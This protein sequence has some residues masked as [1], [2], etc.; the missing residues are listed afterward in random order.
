MKLNK[1]FS[2]L[3]G[4]ALVLGAA[5]CNE[6]AKYDPTPAYNGDEVYFSDSEES[7]V[8]IPSGAT[9]VT[10]NLYRVKAGAELTVGLEGTITSDTETPATSVFSVPT[11]VTFPAE[12]TVVE[13]PIGVTFSAVEP[14]AEYY[15]HLAIAG[16]EHTPYGLSEADFVLTYAPWSEFELYSDK[17]A[18]GT[19]GNPFL[20]E[21]IDGQVYYAKSLVN[22]NQEKYIIIGPRYS[23][24][25]FNYELTVDKSKTVERE[26]TTCYRV[27]MPWTATHYELNGSQFVFM[28]AFSYILFLNGISDPNRVNDE[29][30]YE[31]LEK[32][33]LELSYYNP[34]TGIFSLYLLPTLEG[35]EENGWYSTSF[36]YIQMPGFAKYE[37]EFTY[38]SNR[39]DKVTDQ[40]S[41][42]IQAFRTSDVASFSYKLFT[43]KLSEAEGAEEL[44]KLEADAEAT[45]YYDQTTVFD[46]YLA[47]PG[48]YTI[49]AVGYDAAGDK[50]CDTVWTFTYEPLRAY[51]WKS[52]GFYEY[53]DGFIY[54]L[55]NTESASWDVEVEQSTVDPKLI[56]LVNPYRA[57]NGWPYA[58]AKYDMPGNYYLYIYIEENDLVYI[59]RSPMGIILSADEGAF[60][61]FSAAGYYIDDLGRRP[62]QIKRMGFCGKYENDAITFPGGS[63]YAGFA[64]YM[65]AET[66]DFEWMP[67]NYDPEIP[68]DDEAAQLASE[69]LFYL[70][71]S[72][73]DLSGS[74]AASTKNV[75]RAI[76]GVKVPKADRKNLVLGERSVLNGSLR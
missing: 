6:K 33:N 30:V 17:N 57:G 36:T 12:A 28:D 4:V 51:N 20:G 71:L 52:L 74:A 66:G 13:I 56:R 10:V 25:Y 61:A 64:E 38:L 3:A 67:T 35:Q 34:E 68:Q 55:Y 63:L 24:F 39:V 60:T 73:A 29:K 72:G 47:K 8:A 1:I 31:L 2:A 65:N 62:S 16:E 19:M 43:G 15:L 42:Q 11:M 50:V 75:R 40:E 70:D 41:V 22:D 58:E 18:T 76:N 32:N 48:D 9:Q 46:F 54:D 26:G 69:G 37:L 44:A 14:E 45:L 53:T 59:K 21:E 49:V 27:L 5:S 7:E 23:N